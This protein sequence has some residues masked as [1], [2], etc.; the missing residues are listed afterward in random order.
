M[1]SKKTLEDVDL[2]T[3]P[4]LPAWMLTPKEEKLVYERWRKNTHAKCD[5]LIRLYIECS[6]HYSNVI[7]G[8][9]KCKD[10]NARTQG[11]I[12]QYQEMK[13]LDQERDKYIQEKLDE[14]K[15]IQEYIK[16]RD[17]K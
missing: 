1:N 13:Y 3:N 8:F 9:N 11:C 16:N 15:R 17:S 10:I 2:H 4:N 12:R 6:N 7:E 14:K 5:H